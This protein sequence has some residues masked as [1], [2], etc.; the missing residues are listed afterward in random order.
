M[1]V[2]LI[3][4]FIAMLGLGS[5]SFGEDVV[6]EPDQTEGSNDTSGKNESEDLIEN[7]VFKIASPLPNQTVNEEFVFKGK[8]R[9]FEANFQYELKDGET[10]LESDFITA[11]EGA[12]GWGDF[13]RVITVPE[14]VDSKLILKVF[15]SSAKDGSEINVLEIP[16]KPKL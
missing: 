6:Q 9:V 11:S 3:L 14:T 13:E 5:Y 12:P 2:F 7:E 4:F 1:K 10:V 16:L 15:V 8:A